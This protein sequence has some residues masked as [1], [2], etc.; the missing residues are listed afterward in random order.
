MKLKF[1][2]QPFQEDAARAV[3]AVFEGQQILAGQAKYLRDVGGDAQNPAQGMFA[4]FDADGWKNAPIQ[5]EVRAHILE[6]IRKVQ[7]ENWIKPSG[8]LEG[9]GVN[10][11][12]EMETGVGKTY[13]YIKTIH[14]LYRKYGWMKYM[15][16][17]PS[18]AIREG[19]YK[20][21][22]D[23]EEH[24]MLDYHRRIN[25]FVYNSDRLGE[26]DAF[27]RDSGIHVMIINAQAFA[28]SFNADKNIA[29]R[30]GDKAARIIF[31]RQDSMGG[32]RPID[33]IA[34][35]NPIVVID[36]P[37]SVEGPATAAALKLFKPLFTLRYSATHRNRYNLVYR[38]D[39]VDA[40]RQKL[41]KKI[42]VK[43]IVQT[44]TQGTDGFLFLEEIR[45]A[46]GRNPEAVLR[47]DC[48][49]PG[50]VRQKTSV[51]S[52][53]FDVRE[54]SGGLAEYR[55]GYVVTDIDATTGRVEFQNGIGLGLGEMVGGGNEEMLRRL[56]IRETIRTHLAHEETL[57]AKGIKCL[58]LFFIDEVRK[59]REY[60]GD[61][62][63]GGLYAR[64][65]EE[66]YESARQEY[67]TERLD[68]NPGYAAWL[69]RQGAEG[70][71]AGYFSIDR[72][73]RLVDPKLEGRGRR[74]VADP[75]SNDADAFELIMKG[76]EKL[77]SFDDPEGGRVRFLFSHS[78]L[79][80]GWDNPNVFQ[81]CTL[82]TS[83]ADIRKRQEIGR[84]LRLCV[85]KFG[86]RQDQSVLGAGIYDINVLTVVTSES[87][88]K[89]ARGLQSELA[90]DLGERPARIDAALFEGRDYARRDGTTGVVSP[91]LAAQLNF[92]L[93]ASGYID[94][95]GQLT[96]KYE[97]DKAAGA[98][99]LG[100]AGEGPDIRTES[101]VAILEQ[102][103]DPRALNPANALGARRQALN[104]KQFDSAAFK[105]LWAQIN[106]KSAY[107]V[108]F[109]PE[110][111]IRKSVDSLNRNLHVPAIEY[112]VTGGA[113]AV[114]SVSKETLE[115]GTAMEKTAKTTTRAELVLPDSYRCDLIGEIAEE[116]GL[117]RSDVATI[118]SKVQPDVFAQFRRNPEAFIRRAA[119]LIGEQMA[120][121]IV[122]DIT[123]NKIE[124]RFEETI[125]SENL[126]TAYP[127]TRQVKDT[128]K[129]VYD[130]FVLDSEVEVGF[131][132][133]LEA[134][135]EVVVYTK[136]PRGFYI[137]TPVGKYN[138]DW[139]I[140]FE[141][142]GNK[143]IY[144]VAETKGTLNEFGLD[145][146]E[147]AKI[148]CARKHFKAISA[149]RVQYDFINSYSAL[150]DI[151]ANLKAQDR[152][153]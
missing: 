53:G 30:S 78:A 122:E 25:F 28:S 34:A 135:G 7:K 95:N 80:E 40:F 51:A 14:E 69:A 6:Q 142:N 130:L 75:T 128:A 119:S 36:E 32:R 54:Q 17:V 70:A 13:T 82:K 110:D 74:A 64:M 59:Y 121:V 87:Y 63:V 124:G 83:G 61:R 139:A 24:F 149:D 92:C 99:T 116:T 79:R 86:E 123:Y 48:A 65:F 127:G 103:F 68:L 151:L 84:G 16:V 5:P 23:L 105:A 102:V 18:I 126:L 50:G 3:C 66:E 145:K 29:G 88:E 22:R 112:A 33:V 134:S 90:A 62:A 56:Q 26:L 106:A 8:K 120:N 140:A 133:D 71:H 46:P 10:L 98:V 136:L 57:F 12:V 115:S 72:Q 2:H 125:F 81:I 77:L 1:K 97:A 113:L 9:E 129:G 143:H 49:A 43:G 131:C 37:Q 58:S 147:A 41:V 144:F 93:I 114:D 45:T 96:A 11:S 104:R 137:D 141:H 152:R 47:Y 21:F 89:F 146:V 101:V 118:L 108:T 52:V 100:A 44:G 4:N 148:K 111:L 138:P 20:S 94:M 132:K 42:A 31:T 60:Q 38:L 107:T 150:H 27:A 109:D 19:V 67:L 85:D 39:A 15:I 117:T 91:Q 73:N 76:K 153:M 55:H 35:M